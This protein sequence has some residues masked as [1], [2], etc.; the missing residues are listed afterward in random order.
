MANEDKSARYHRLRRRTSLLDTT[1]QAVLLLALV[2]SGASSAIRTNVEAVVGTSLVPLVIVYVLVIA[3]LSD[4][5]HLPF[6]FYQG[7]VLERRY[8]LSTE[9]AARWLTDHVK[10]AAIVLVALMVA[11]VV[12]ASL[13]AVQPGTV[14][15]F[16]GG[17]FSPPR[18]SCLRGSRPC[19]CFRCSTTPAARRV[20]T[21]ASDC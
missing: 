11:G 6:A 21:C 3:V 20:T 4:L 9:T 7:V 15:A 14:V 2:L 5:L 18:S 12:V 13:H 8:G 17:L 16:R 19:C 10:A 1:V